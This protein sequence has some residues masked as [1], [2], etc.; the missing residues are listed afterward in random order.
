MLIG[1]NEIVTQ[2]E[3]ILRQTESQVH[4]PSEIILYWHTCSHCKP[5]EL[6]EVLAKVYNSLNACNIDAIKKN[7]AQKVHSS[8]SQSLNSQISNHSYGSK[9][10]P[11]KNINSLHKQSEN[12]FAYPE[13]GSLLM[14][15]RKDALDKIKEIIKKIDKPKK[16]VEIEVLLCERRIQHSN[17][18]GINLLKLANAA[19]GEK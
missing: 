14:T 15:I 5:T 4:D 1:S 7:S 17:K 13:T 16:M 19:T 11:Q 12:F 9:T 8:F 3:N 10:P 2:A 6:A 18:S